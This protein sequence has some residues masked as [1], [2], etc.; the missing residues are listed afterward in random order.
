MDNQEDSFDFLQADEVSKLKDEALNTIRFGNNSLEKQFKRD[1]ELTSLAI[2]QWGQSEQDKIKAEMLLKSMLLLFFGRVCYR[3]ISDQCF[4]PFDT[5]NTYF[6]HSTLTHFPIAAILLHGSRVLVEFP[7]EIAHQLVDWFITDKNSRRYLATHGI[8]ALTEAEVIHKNPKDITAPYSARKCLKE[9]KV[10]GAH[11]VLNLLS[12]SISGLMANACFGFSIYSQQ[13]DFW[14]VPRENFKLSN[15]SEVED[16]VNRAEHYGI[17]LAL[18]GVGNQHFASKKIIRN[19]GEHGHLYINFYKGLA[20]K[21]RSGLL[22]GIEQS[23]PGKS[24][25]YGGEH[26]LSLSDKAY[27]ASGG[28]FF[29]KKPTLLEIY[30]KDYQGLSVLPFASYYDSLWNFL[31]EDTWVLIKTNFETCQ[32]LLNLLDQEKSLVFIKQLLATPGGGSQE[33]FDRLLAPYFPVETTKNESES[34]RRVFSA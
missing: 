31:T 22:I 14:K 25:Q 7:I 2:V 30:Q 17:N 1:I 6:K 10:S 29:C 32:Y 28:D 3:H 15:T 23:A 12:N 11:A 8:S 26:D 16:N 20:Q 9:E 33:D 18:G 19:N 34:R 27:S 5:L 4:Y 24:D 13:W 21:K